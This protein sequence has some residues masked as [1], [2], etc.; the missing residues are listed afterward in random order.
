MG[1]IFSI[2]K[3]GLV[4]R[5]SQNFLGSGL[6]AHLINWAPPALRKQ[7]AMGIVSLSPHYYYG[8]RKIEHER[9][10]KSRGRLIADLIAP[11]VSDKSVV[12]DFGCGPGYAARAAADHVKSVFGVDISDGALA[13]ARVLNGRSNIEYLNVSAIDKISLC[14]IDLVYSFA[15]VQHLTDDRVSDILKGLHPLLK[16]DGRLVLHVVIDGFGWR[17]EHEWRAD[18]TMRGRIKLNHGLNCFD[19]TRPQIEQLLT[20][21]GFRVE[22]IIAAAEMTDA[23]A[24]ADIVSQNILYAIKR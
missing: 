15:V 14:S 5:G 20:D 8:P 10:V 17:T 16:T 21:A 24:D 23:D 3:T 4:N 6:F 11:L 13:A 7:V 12:M 9:L 22:K 2:L 19:R 18:Q 1:R